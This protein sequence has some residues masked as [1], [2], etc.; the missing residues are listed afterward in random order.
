LPLLLLLLI[1]GRRRTPNT[2]ASAHPP[3]AARPAG[4]PGQLPL[5]GEHTDQCVRVCVSS[6]IKRQFYLTSQ[7]D[8]LIGAVGVVLSLLRRRGPLEFNLISI[9]L[10]CVCV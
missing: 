2:F 3:A 6:L 4:R 8:G 10:C 9:S 1:D 7:I 5:L